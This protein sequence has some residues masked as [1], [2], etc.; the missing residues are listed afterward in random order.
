VTPVG[1]GRRTRPR[2]PNRI[3]QG[4]DVTGAE[5][6]F[7]N[8]HS[9]ISG[10][11]GAGPGVAA[12]DFVVLVF[13][14]DKTYWRAGSRRVKSARPATDG[15]FTIADLPAGEYLIGALTD[16]EPGDADRPS[17]LEQL[18][19]TSLK[20]TLGDGEKKRQDIRLR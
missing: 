16:L 11:L 12:S 4:S 15:E 13:P 10:T 19:P 14:A 2:L 7:S 5:L 8:R 1:N 6:T 3:G 20:I 18:V 9:E 17:F